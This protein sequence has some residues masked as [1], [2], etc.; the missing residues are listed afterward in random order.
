MGPVAAYKWL[1]YGSSAAGL[2]ILGIWAARWLTRRA[3]VPVV[4]T[5]PA[6][7]RGAS[8]LSLPVILLVAWGVG[9][10]VLGPFTADFTPRH[11]AYRA[12][13]P[14]AALWGAITLALCVFVQIARMRGRA[15]FDS[16]ASAG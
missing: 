4:R 13:P 14:A 11:L 6:W 7:L 2:V 15:T 8:W 16:T 5:V 9:M 10:L 12:L 1:Q 3:A